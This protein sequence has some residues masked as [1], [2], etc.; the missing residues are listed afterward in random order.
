MKGRVFGGSKRKH[1]PTCQWSI[2]IH[3]KKEDAACTQNHDTPCPS[4]PSDPEKRPSSL[5]KISQ[6]SVFSPTVLEEQLLALT[7]PSGMR[8]TRCK[9]HPALRLVECCNAEF[10]SDHPDSRSVSLSRGIPEK[11]R[12]SGRSWKVNHASFVPFCLPS[13]PTSSNPPRKYARGKV[14]PFIAE[15]PHDGVAARTLPKRNKAYA[16]DSDLVLPS[17]ARFSLPQ[18][19]ANTRI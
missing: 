11:A 10:M 4:R 5:Q 12:E 16:V 14:N 13:H 17:F 9:V 15:K 3:T 8:D 7:N 18:D 2:R 6:L 19:L 1:W